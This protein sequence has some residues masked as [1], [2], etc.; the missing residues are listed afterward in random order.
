LERRAD[1]KE[2][3]ALWRI[4]RVGEGVMKPKV[5]WRDMGEEFEAAVVGAEYVPLNT[6]YY[7]PC[8][9]ERRAV[10]LAALLQSEP[11][12]LMGRVLGE[13]ARGGW[14]RHFAWLVSMVPMP[15]RLWSWWCDEVVDGELDVLAD[16]ALAGDVAGLVRCVEGMMGLREQDWEAMREE[17]SWQRGA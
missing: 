15:E 4:Y 12:K 13:R 8:E 11:V 3:H 17:L 1:W 5:V 14:R 10:A 9:D 6:A 7:I 2:G 16:G